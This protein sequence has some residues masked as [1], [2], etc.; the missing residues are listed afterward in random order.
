MSDWYNYYT[1]LT[2]GTPPTD[3]IRF[4]ATNRTGDPTVEKGYV[5]NFCPG[6]YFPIEKGTETQVRSRI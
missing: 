4:Y 6:D 1:K 3:Y 2:N 5:E